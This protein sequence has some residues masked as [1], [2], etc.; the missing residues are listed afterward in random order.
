MT[1]LDKFESIMEILVLNEEAENI[2]VLNNIC[3]LFKKGWSPGDSYVEFETIEKE[4]DIPEKHHQEYVDKAIESIDELVEITKLH[5]R[6][7]LFLCDP[8]NSN[9]L[10][11]FIELEKYA[12]NPV[13]K[14]ENIL[15]WKP[16]EN[17]TLVEVYNAIMDF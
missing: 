11:S 10:E 12:A 3:I 7:N 8:P 16:F 17:W 4:K 9:V 2:Q 13:I 5:T 14:P 15:V 1:I 6:I